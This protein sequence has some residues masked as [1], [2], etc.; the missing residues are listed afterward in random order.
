MKVRVSREENAVRSAMERT[1]ESEKIKW[2]ETD[3]LLV[4]TTERKV[5]TLSSDDLRKIFVQRTYDGY[6]SLLTDVTVDTVAYGLVEIGGQIYPSYDLTVVE[7]KGKECVIPRAA[8]YDVNPLA[9]SECKP[10]ILPSLSGVGSEISA[11]EFFS[12]CGYNNITHAVHVRT[13]VVYDLS[14]ATVHVISQYNGSKG[15]PSCYAYVLMID[16]KILPVQMAE[17]ELVNGSA[18][19]GI[20]EEY[21]TFKFNFNDPGIDDDLY[22][23]KSELMRRE[24]KVPASRVSALRTWQSQ[25]AN[26]TISRSQLMKMADILKVRIGMV[27]LDTLDADIP[28]IFIKVPRENRDNSAVYSNVEGLTDEL[29]AQLN[30]GIK[31]PATVYDIAGITQRAASNELTV[32]DMRTLLDFVK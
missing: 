10:V 19:G 11:S 5:T 28:M 26:G 32:D 31:I 22:F 17:L 6:K 9:V 2:T 20:E 14:R 27:L 16:H 3:K 8:D 23:L 7:Y 29:L 18:T 4:V 24:F 30:K 21:R 15:V 1:L 25:I 13:G 12:A